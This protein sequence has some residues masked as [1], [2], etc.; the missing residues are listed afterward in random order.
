MVDYSGNMMQLGQVNGTGDNRE[1]F[2][3]FYSNE[4]I[5][6]TR[7]NLVVT[8]LIK[9]VTVPKGYGTYEMKLN[10]P[11]SVKRYQLGTDVV[12]E[13]ST[14]G[15]RRI[16]IDDVLYD[17]RYDSLLDE[18]MTDSMFREQ[19]AF[20]TGFAMA[21]KRDEDSLRMIIKSGM[22]TNHTE[23]AAYFGAAQAFDWQQYTQ[24]HTFGSVAGDEL[25][26]Q[27]I[28]DTLN[29]AKFDFHQNHC[30]G[31]P[32]VLMPHEQI[33]A[34]LTYVAK[35][36][37]TTAWAH[38]DVNGGGVDLVKGDVNVINGLRLVGT[39]AFGK[40]SDETAGTPNEPLETSATNKIAT[41]PSEKYRADYS[42]V[43]AVMFFPECAANVVAQGI[44]TEVD[45]VPTH[46][47]SEL[48]KTYC[49]KG[50][51]IINPQKC[52]VLYKNV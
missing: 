31:T 30:M 22:I 18:L 49:I 38:K 36:G 5:E 1:R 44:T 52:K 9:N 45:R 41:S 20:E 42:N 37:L 35:N 10:A 7:E 14:F 46:I 13:T 43:Q 48:V 47:G 24:N 2:R 11:R 16:Q 8:P 3:I 6:R 40:L 39:H 33:N 32:T 27:V 12:P 21:Q 51:E 23:L 28:W 17:A 50:S 19:T 26:G 4:I 34:V 15:I 29:E 25:D